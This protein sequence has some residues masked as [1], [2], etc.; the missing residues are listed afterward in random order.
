MSEETYVAQSRPFPAV[1]KIRIGDI[2]QIGIVV[3]DI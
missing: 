1:R 2:Y 3:K